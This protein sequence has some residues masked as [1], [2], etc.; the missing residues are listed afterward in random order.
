MSNYIDQGAFADKAFAEYEFGDGVMVTDTSGWEYTTPG[1]ARTRKVYVETEREDDGPAPRWVLN[2]TV[3]FDPV[4]GALSEAYAMDEKGQIWGNIASSEPIKE[5]RLIVDVSY[6]DCKVSAR[7]LI[8]MLSNAVQT[9][10]MV[11]ELACGGKVFGFSTNYLHQRSSMND[12]PHIRA[13]ALEQAAEELLID[14]N[15]EKPKLA[16]RLR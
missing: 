4:S 13:M 10:L 2:F 6:L 5:I 9:R 15:A 12:T 11:D 1:H 16:P 3:R 8:G 14:V 7:E